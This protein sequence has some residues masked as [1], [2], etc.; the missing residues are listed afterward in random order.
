MSKEANTMHKTLLL[1]SAAALSLPKGAA[2]GL[3][4]RCFHPQWPAAAPSPTVALRVICPTT[5]EGYAKA[6]ELGADFIEPDLVMTKDGVLIAPRAQSERHHRRGPPRQVRQPQ[7]QDDG[8]W[9]GRKK[10]GSPAGFT[11]GGN[12]N[13]A[14]IQP[15]ADRLQQGV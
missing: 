4:A 9:R 6:I 14:P 7:A 12:Q 8:G 1:A 11:T 5:L 10:A 3:Q 15:R 2:G 13:P